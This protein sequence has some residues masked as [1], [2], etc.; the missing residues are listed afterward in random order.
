MSLGKDP[1]SPWGRTAWPS[2]HSVPWGVGEG[3]SSCRASFVG[4][5]G[6]LNVRM[7]IYGWAKGATAAMASCPHFC[8]QSS[9][10][11]KS[12]LN[13]N[14]SKRYQTIITVRL[15]CACSRPEEN[16]IRP[17]CVCS[18][19][20]SQPTAVINSNIHRGVHGGWHSGQHRGAHR[21]LTQGCLRGLT[22]GHKP[23]FGFCCEWRV[24]T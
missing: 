2:G 14:W 24:Y 13:A 5:S 4:T 1:P 22:H 12:R 10:L 15:M 20:P 7:V 9:L 3:A 19:R 6:R 11:P 18:P 8:P 17:V 23:R 21:G 16:S